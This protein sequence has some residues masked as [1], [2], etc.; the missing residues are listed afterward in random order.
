MALRCN[1]AKSTL[2]GF[3]LEA[4]YSPGE[5]TEAFVTAGYSKTAFDTFVAANQTTG[6]P[7]DLDGNEFPASPR[8]TGSVGMTHRFS[9]RI[10]LDIDGA[11][12]DR[13][14]LSI[15]NNRSQLSDSFFIVNARI[16]YAAERWSEHL[17]ARNLFDRQY[18]TRRRLD[19]SNTAGNSRVLGISLTAQI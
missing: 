9:N 8:W 14:F 16:G 13:S 12:T 17:Y 2:Y 3:E 6:V 19:D 11:F 15:F 1:S 18:L 4:F 10:D 5:R 7:E